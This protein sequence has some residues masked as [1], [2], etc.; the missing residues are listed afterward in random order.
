MKNLLF[1]AFKKEKVS[2]KAGLFLAWMENL[3]SKK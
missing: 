2:K 1:P 3:G